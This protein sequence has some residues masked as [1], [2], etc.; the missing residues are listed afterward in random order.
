V[1]SPANEGWICRVTVA[2]HGESRDFEVRV[3]QAELARLDPGSSEPGDLVR[4]SFEFLLAREPK[5]SILGSF[6]LG[7]I[8]RYYP[9]YERE[10]GRH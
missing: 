8:S 4:H 1:S 3:T 6:G 7:V 5:E 9:E 2:D 10:I